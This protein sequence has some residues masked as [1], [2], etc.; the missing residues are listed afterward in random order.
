MTWTFPLLLEPFQEYSPMNLKLSTLAVGVVFAVGVGSLALAPQPAQ[1][2]WVVFD[3][4]NF[5]QNILTALRTLQSNLN[6]VRS[7][8]TQLQQLTNQITSLGNEA[9][10]LTALPQNI[11]S[12]YQ[13]TFQQFQQQV[14][15]TQGLMKNLT[16]VRTQF[17]QQYP[18]YAATNPDFQNFSGIIDSWNQTDRQNLQDAL[19]SGAAVLGQMQSGQSNVVSIVAASQSAT[20]A[21]QASQATNQLQG[22]VADELMKLNAQQAMMQQVQLQREAKDDA[23]RDAMKALRVKNKSDWSQPDA[24]VTPGVNLTDG[25]N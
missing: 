8:T 23:E 21:L 12:Q 17:Q 6:E 4:T 15:Q 14:Q 9:R 25:S 1:A 7:Y 5:S 18:N 3:P 2:Q 13:Q 19:A 11:L 20:G 10:N 24:P 22:V 16:N